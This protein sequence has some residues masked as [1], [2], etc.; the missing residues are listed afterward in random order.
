MDFSN[1]ISR[2]NWPK[3]GYGEWV[4]SLVQ[5]LDAAGFRVVV[6]SPFKLPATYAP[7]GWRAI[8]AYAYIAVESY[9]SGSAILAHAD[10][11]GGA[12][13]WCNDQYA[14][15]L[16][17]Y[18]SAG[19]SGE[20]LLLT[21]HF[22][23]TLSGNPAGRAGVSEDEWLAAIDARCN[24]AKELFR[25]KMYSGYATY[26]WNYNQMNEATANL[27]A[28]EQRYSAHQLPGDRRGRARR[29]NAL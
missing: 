3:R 24:A 14:A 4:A 18:E 12:A 23:Q 26:A 21:E 8:A 9:L 15:M 25:R 22:G 20:R 29:M 19:V 7:D 17:S 10:D 13:T 6:F 16:S 2:T 28:Y 1:E 5:Q 11:E 27:V